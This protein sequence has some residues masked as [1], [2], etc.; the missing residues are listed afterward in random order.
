MKFGTKL[1]RAARTQI[2]RRVREL[3]ASGLAL[4]V[5]C[6]V[7]YVECV[8]TCRTDGGQHFLRLFHGN[9]MRGST[10]F[11]P[12]GEQHAAERHE[13]RRTHHGH[14]D[15]VKAPRYF[16]PKLDWT[17]NQANQGT[18]AQQRAQADARAALGRA[19]GFGLSSVQHVQA[20]AQS[21]PAP[22]AVATPSAQPK[23]P[24][25]NAAPAAHIDTPQTTQAPG[26]PEVAPLTLPSQLG[27]HAPMALGGHG[28]GD[29]LRMP[30]EAGVSAALVDALKGRRRS[31]VRR[32]LDAGELDLSPSRLA[33]TGAG[34]DLGR[35]WQRRTAP[36]TRQTVVGVCLDYSGSMNAGNGSAQ[37]SRYQI[38]ARACAMILRVLERERIAC[39][40]WRYAGAGAEPVRR[41]LPTRTP[42]AQALRA[43][44][45][46][47]DGNS[48]DAPRAAHEAAQ[49]LVK[50]R[51]DRRVLVVLCDDDMRADA[52]EWAEIE[53]AG[54]EVW[55][56]SIAEQPTDPWSTLPDYNGWA[57]RYRTGANE[58]SQGW[59]GALRA[60][61]GRVEV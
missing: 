60:G 10:T 11:E 12:H 52:S 51:A 16:V 38:A 37:G 54:V 32:G 20:D 28:S 55:G 19:P 39:A 5:A 7:T 36:D 2:L 53:R 13:Y 33:I 45:I 8:E 34:L 46:R 3:H 1:T 18:K 23:Q 50:M 49:Q 6:A 22:A 21:G 44:D 24:D 29:F 17:A 27:T 47:P 14:A 59:T 30:G 26:Q 41:L 25:P 9:G 61:L 43:I 35:A 48:T 57:A 56:I 4:H 31:I 58:L 40:V 42:L 15:D